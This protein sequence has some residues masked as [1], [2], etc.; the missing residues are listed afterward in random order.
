MIYQPST[1]DIISVFLRRKAMFM[2]VFGIVCLCGGGYLLLKQPL[3]LSTA[4]LVLH[5][6]SQAVPDIDRTMKPTQ[7]EGTNEHREILYSDSDILHS[8]AI[9]RDGSQKIGWARLYPQIAAAPVSDSHK[10]DQ[11]EQAFPSNLVVD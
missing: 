5:F 10:M 6:D 4:S 8:P 7:L 1:R 9:T 11:A 2:L 3:Y